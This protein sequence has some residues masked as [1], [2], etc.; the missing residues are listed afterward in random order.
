M[1]RTETQT[2]SP[3]QADFDAPRAT[4]T[5]ARVAP[6]TEPISAPEL[7]VRSQSTTA[8]KSI[9]Q[10]AVTMRARA[11]GMLHP[12]CCGGTGEDGCIV[13]DTLTRSDPQRGFPSHPAALVVRNGGGRG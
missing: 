13:D 11:D 8:T 6:L 4:Q 9:G 3:F 7:R 10:I 5:L 1:K 2:R 12:C